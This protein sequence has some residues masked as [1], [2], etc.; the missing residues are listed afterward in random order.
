M[1]EMITKIDVLIDLKTFD[2]T[3]YT[4]RMLLRIYFY[5]THNIASTQRKIPSA[6]AS[7]L[8]FFPSFPP[9]PVC[10]FLFFFFI[11]SLCSVPYRFFLLENRLVFYVRYINTHIATGASTDTLQ[12]LQRHAWF[13]VMLAF[14]SIEH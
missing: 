10:I 1:A 3:H 13:A 2:R 12:L 4:S 11:F 8:F 7:F 9:P 14:M 6:F 5:C